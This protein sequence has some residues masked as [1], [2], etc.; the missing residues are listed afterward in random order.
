[1]S[2]TVCPFCGAYAKRSCE[3]EGGDEN[4]PW[5]DLDN[6]PGL[7]PD[8]WRELR[9]ERARLEKEDRLLSASGGNRD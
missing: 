5:D 9:D 3:F 2:G 6:E 1:M 8:C 7:D 4:C